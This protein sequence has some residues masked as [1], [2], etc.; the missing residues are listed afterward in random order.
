MPKSITLGTG[1]PSCHLVLGQPEKALE[2][3]TFL[4][5]LRRVLE[6]RPSGKPMPLV[7]AMI[8]VAIAGLYVSVIEDGMQMQAWREPQLAALQEQL[9]E[10]NL[11]PYVASSL[12]FERARVLR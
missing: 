12:S 6:F 4:H 11:R 7:A 5:Q 1:T 10:I 9:K 2:E 8:N 3:L